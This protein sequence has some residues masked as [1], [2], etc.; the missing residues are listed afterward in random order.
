MHREGHLFWLPMW[1]R[2]QECRTKNLS[3]GQ[4]DDAPRWV[5]RGCWVARR[6]FRRTSGFDKTLGETELVFPGLHSRSVNQIAG[7]H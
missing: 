1:Y 7:I 3:R 4:A 5:L 2:L 6:W